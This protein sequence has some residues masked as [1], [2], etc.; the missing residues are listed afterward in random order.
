MVNVCLF[1][2]STGVLVIYL[3]VLETR[4]SKTH[5]GYCSCH[6]LNMTVTQRNVS[7]YDFFS[8]Y[9]DYSWLLIFV[10]SEDTVASLICTDPLDHA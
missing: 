8:K 7:W 3:T 6:E 10:H 5:F 9:K 1:L 2:F 4:V